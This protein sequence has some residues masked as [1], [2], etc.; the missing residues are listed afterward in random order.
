MTILTIKP[1]QRGQAMV[2]VV[3]MTGVIIAL[4]LGVW[5][6]GKFHDIQASTIQA[7]RYAAWERTVHTPATLSNT[8][9]ENQ[10]RA[11]IFTWNQNAFLAADS[12]SG[13]QAWGQ[14]SRMWRNH[15]DSASKLLIKDPAAVTVT[16]PAKAGKLP[17]NAAGAITNIVSK[18]S[19]VLGAITGGQALEADGLYTSEVSV[20]LNA[21][22]LPTTKPADFNFAPLVL[23]EKSA[24]VTDSWDADGAPQTAL[25]TRSFAPASAF[26]RVNTILAPVTWALSWIE[27]A[28]NNFNPGQICPDIVPNDRVGNGI[29]P[30]Y[31]GPAAGVSRCY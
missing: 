20:A 15:S 31:R 19:G 22:A 7:A 2:E 30:V 3:V 12:K 14:Q 6:L 26:Q 16:T 27:P 21:A 17:G 25:R 11:R 24:L 8:T 13:T 23:K 1:T 29:L 5:Y 10:T 9:L 4:F 18:V 28:F